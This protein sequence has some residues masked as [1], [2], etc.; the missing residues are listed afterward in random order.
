MANETEN[1]KPLQNDTE[2]PSPGA[3]A[4]AAIAAEVNARQPDAESD[5][6]AGDDSAEGVGNATLSR[7]QRRAL[8]FNKAG[9]ASQS[10]APHEGG[11][12]SGGA[13]S[14]GAQS[15]RMTRMTTKRA[16]RGT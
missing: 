8:Q 12:S 3:I 5:A 16:S 10:R 9:N 1:T 14:G 7:A 6:Q 11:K 4:D 15:S 13:P 2:L